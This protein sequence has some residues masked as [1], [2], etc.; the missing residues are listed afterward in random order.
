[1][2][3]PLPAC[4][5]PITVP[6][7]WLYRAAVA[8]RNAPYNRGVGI[9]RLD[10]PVIS[11]GNITV[12]GTGKT[13]MVAWIAEV[14]Q[15]ASH[16]PVI[17]MR[18]Y[19]GARGALSD[20]QADYAERLPDVPVLA[21]PGR[22]AALREFLRVAT[23]V[24]CVLLDDG[25][26]HR[27]LARDLDLVLIDATRQ[28]GAPHLLPAGWLREPMGSL[29]RADAVVVTRAAAVDPALS[30]E[31]E[32]R[33]GE[34]PLAWSRHEWTSIDLHSPS[35]RRQ[36]SAKWLVGRSVATMFGVGNPPAVRS[37]VQAAGA[38]IQ[39]TVPVRDHEHYS[40]TIIHA[41]RR[42][43]EKTGVLVTTS[44]DWVKLRHL[45]E[46]SGWPGII[47]VPQVRIEVFAGNDALR[48]RIL[49]TAATRTKHP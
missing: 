7:S 39:E 15:E 41:A 24:D 36:V 10:R 16:K 46:L 44:K 17:A 31:I 20:E 37:Q 30:A 28:A 49:K 42:A 48:E 32:R 13:P 47:A 21:A 38:I 1:M 25:F 6:A 35:A 12:G 8:W 22:A 9:E 27:Q 33:H 4:L 34:P 45:I 26:Q 18:G 23:H 19:R 11:V 14:L 40:P 5:A 2:S 29:R 43:S 3:G